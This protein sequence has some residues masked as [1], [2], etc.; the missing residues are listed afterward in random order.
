MFH[1]SHMIQL[2]FESYTK[3]VTQLV[4]FHFGG[5]I[6]SCILIIATPIPK[7]LC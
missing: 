3:Q 6:L 1:C 4:E 5:Q 7:E 2:L